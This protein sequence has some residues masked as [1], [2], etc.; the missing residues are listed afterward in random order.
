M[1]TEAS[2]GR[3]LA[4]AQCGEGTQ[5]LGSGVE[6]QANRR[7]R[8]RARAHRARLGLTTKPPTH[9]RHD[10]RDPRERDHDPEPRHPLP[11]WRA[12]RAVEV[13]EIGVAVGCR[14]GGDDDQMDG[15]E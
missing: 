8:G 1:L 4:G 6:S 3:Q 5:C 12:E 10:Q 9:E 15:R 13:A 14:E 7:M 2:R 11:P